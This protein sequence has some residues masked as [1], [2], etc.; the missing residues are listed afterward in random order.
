MGVEDHDLVLVGL[1]EEYAV[2]GRRIGGDDGEAIA[3]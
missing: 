2:D 1:V 3:Y